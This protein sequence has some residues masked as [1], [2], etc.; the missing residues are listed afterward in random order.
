MTFNLIE[1]SSAEFGR[2]G[3]E[4]SH[5]NIVPSSSGNGRNINVDVIAVPLLVIVA[6]NVTQNRQTFK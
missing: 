4:P 5:F 6:C 3:F 2:R 1:S